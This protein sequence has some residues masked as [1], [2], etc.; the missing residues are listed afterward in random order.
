MISRPSPAAAA[1]AAASSHLSGFWASH[2]SG[3]HCFLITAAA[4]TTTTIT[5]CYCQRRHLEATFKAAQLSARPRSTAVVNKCRLIMINPDLMHRWTRPP[6]AGL[7]AMH[8]WTLARSTKRLNNLLWSSPWGA[9]DGPLR[10]SSPCCRGAGPR[11][12]G[13][14]RRSAANWL[15]GRFGSTG[16]EWL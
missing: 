6:R 8:Y 5:R 11:L 14:A 7:L 13:R 10:R 15:S 12:S 4:A 1:A 2:I 16:N 9:V 3:G